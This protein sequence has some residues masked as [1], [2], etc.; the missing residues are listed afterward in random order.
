MFENLIQYPNQMRTF[1]ILTVMILTLYHIYKYS[2]SAI[3]LIKPCIC[4]KQSACT[5]ILD[6]N[7]AA[8]LIFFWIKTTFSQQQQNES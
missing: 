4:S 7:A 3:N 8:H 6:E 2:P 1:L 5:T